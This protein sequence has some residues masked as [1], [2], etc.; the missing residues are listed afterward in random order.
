MKTKLIVISRVIVGFIG[1]VMMA[2]E[3]LYPDKQKWEINILG[4]FLLLLACLGNKI[5]ALCKKY[6]ANSANICK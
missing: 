2:N 3:Q 6:F 4:L 5:P 1:F